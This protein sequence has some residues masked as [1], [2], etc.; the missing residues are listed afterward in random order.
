MLNQMIT[1]NESQ[2]EFYQRWQDLARPYFAWQFSP[3]ASSRG[4]RVAD[5]GCGL[6]N[7]TD[8]LKDK[9]YYLGV[10]TFAGAKLRP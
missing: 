4:N 2:A 1:Q 7:F 5:L 9:E 6:G 8:Y 10:D 3:F